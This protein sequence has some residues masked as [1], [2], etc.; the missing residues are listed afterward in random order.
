MNIRS[1]VLTCSILFSCLAL[2]AQ[3]PIHGLQEKNA[4]YL[5]KMESEG[6]EFRSQIITEFNAENAQQNVNIKLK[7]GSTYQLVAMGDSDVKE[8]ALEV[9]SSGK[10]ELSELANSESSGGEEVK[11]L[12]PE[13]SGKFKITLSVKSF[14]D[15]GKGFVSFMVL[16]K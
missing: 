9:R 1:F 11:V 16:R 8:L 10:F 2:H 4:Q 5:E 13:K 3:K 7:A 14:S 6:F 12:V 15:S